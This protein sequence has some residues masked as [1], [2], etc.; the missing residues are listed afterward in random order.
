MLDLLYVHRLT[1]S[2]LCIY[3]SYLKVNSSEVKMHILLARASAMPST[4]PIVNG[5]VLA[6]NERA[7]VRTG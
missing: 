4:M 6:V 1:G 5:C 7:S 2:F 3:L